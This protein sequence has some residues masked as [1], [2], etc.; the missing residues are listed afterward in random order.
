MPDFIDLGADIPDVAD[1][2]I[3]HHPLLPYEDDEQQDVEEYERIVHERY[4]GIHNVECDQETADVE[5]QAL[6]PSVRD[7]KLW[8]VKCA[9]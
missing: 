2:R 3:R 9:V 6:L 5:Q 8:M 1:R 7:P 4:A